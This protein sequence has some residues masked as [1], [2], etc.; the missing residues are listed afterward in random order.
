MIEK[1]YMHKASGDL[2]LA[3]HHNPSI[4]YCV[5]KYGE[6]IEHFSVFNSYAFEYLGEL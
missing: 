1:V 4:P 2:V 5:M 6:R 3:V